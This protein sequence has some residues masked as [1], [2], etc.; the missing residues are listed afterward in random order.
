[1]KFDYLINKSLVLILWKLT[2]QGHDVKM[3]PGTLVRR[4]E[5]YYL[6]RGEGETSPEIPEDWL[7]LVAAVPPELKGLM[8]NCEYQLSLTAG[9][10]LA[11][12]EGLKEFGLE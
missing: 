1:M 12:A 9:D 2:D 10:F 8:K 7:D 11:M 5:S 3:F 6:S 4:S